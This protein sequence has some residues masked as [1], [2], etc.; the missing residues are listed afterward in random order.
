[1]L[2]RSRR[3]G[4]KGKWLR[5]LLAACAVLLVTAIPVLAEGKEN[6]GMA[7]ETMV[8]A[9]TALNYMTVGSAYI[10][11]PGSQTLVA[12]I[13][14]GTQQIERAELTV[15]NEWTGEEDRI[16]AERLDTESAVFS[17][18]YED[19]SAAGS[20]LAVRLQYTVNGQE[21]QVE[22][23]EIGMEIRYGVNTEVET[24]PNEIG[25]N[26]DS[27]MNIVAVDREGNAVGGKE[28]GAALAEAEAEAQTFAGGAEP[29]GR[30]NLVLVLDPGHD[31]TH[32]G[33]QGF[34]LGEEQLN[35]KIAQ[36]C[37]ASLEKC[38]G[39]TVYMTREDSGE[40]PSPG[41]PKGTCNLNRVKLAERVGADFYISFHI[42]SSVS[43]QPKGVEIYYP[44][45]NYRPDLSGESKELAEKVLDKLVALGLEEREV[46]VW[47]SQNGS[48]YPDGSLAD[49]LTITSECKLRGIPSILIEHAFIS[50]A[51]DAAFLSS[52]ENLKK[53]GEAD[54]EA[55]K[56]YFGLNEE[57]L[58][59]EAITYAMGQ[60]NITL[61]A[62]YRSSGDSVEFL[63][64]I[65]NLDTQTWETLQ[66]W[67]GQS[68]G[69]VWKPSLH[70]YW[71]HVKARDDRGNTA[72]L[73]VSFRPDK[74]Y[75]IGEGGSD[76]EEDAAYDRVRAHVKELH[77]KVKALM[78]ES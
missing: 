16:E 5:P 9:D 50:N 8:Q 49:Y 60:E 53:L 62:N 46:K 7:E 72:E 10:E 25:V 63:W 36:Y 24:A 33:A 74:D 23:S 40:C 31:N 48:T 44:N 20:Y 70:N 55:I 39:V 66:G 30:Q 61:G 54:A 77:K 1:M 58:E 18:S 67:S 6:A 64:Q 56:E 3:K 76:D 78:G 26:E 43:S 28:I 71:V 75:T 14:D 38:S 42:N 51:E 41:T 32:A 2:D 17:R 65:Y 69:I 47:N 13:G 22:L 35:L 52:E 37:R 29:R 45:E 11:A 12:G 15:V 19:D 73:T 27:S 57:Y 4:E 68:D 34:G 21:Y 59:I